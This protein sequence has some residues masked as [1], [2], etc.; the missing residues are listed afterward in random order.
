MKDTIKQNNELRESQL[1]S[2][3]ATEMSKSEIMAITILNGLLSNSNWSTYN[4][5]DIEELTNKAVEISKLLIK[6]VNQ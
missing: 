4:D 5:I 1:L 2:G 6:K 3:K